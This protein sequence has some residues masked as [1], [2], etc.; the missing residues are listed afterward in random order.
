[1]SFKQKCV[2]LNDGHLMPVLGY[3]TYQ[4][5]EVIKNEMLRVEG[6]KRKLTHDMWEVNSPFLSIVH[7]FC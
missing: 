1:M 2:E 4:N 3:G 7:S 5:P 6:R